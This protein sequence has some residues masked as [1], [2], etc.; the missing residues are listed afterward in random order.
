MNRK[1]G[2]RSILLWHVVP[3]FPGLSKV[4]VLGHGFQAGP[5]VYGC[6][7]KNHRLVPRQKDE[8]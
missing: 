3:M 2:Q 1:L 6:N 5:G 4:H 7:Q 8:D